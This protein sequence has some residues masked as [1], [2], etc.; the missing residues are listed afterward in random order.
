MALTKCPECS[1]KISD[2]APQCPNCGATSEAMDRARFANGCSEGCL[3]L[4]I[5]AFAT[6][7]LIFLAIFL[8]ST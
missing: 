2:S 6:P 8:F 4:M 7:I 1:K 3:S 5:L